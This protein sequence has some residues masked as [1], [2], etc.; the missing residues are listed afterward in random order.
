[1]K[2]CVGF[3]FLYLS[4]SVSN[5]PISKGEY[6]N[7]IRTVLALFFLFWYIAQPFSLM[8]TMLL[9][10]DVNMSPVQTGF[11]LNTVPIALFL[12]NYSSWAKYYI[13]LFIFYKYASTGL[14]LFTYQYV[15]MYL[16]T[17]IYNIYIHLEL[18]LF[19]IFSMYIQCTSGRIKAFVILC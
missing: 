8:M 9:N 13:P 3:I 19:T 7:V 2:A 12:L 14:A 15:S 17:S 6:V 11:K 18:L 5:K 4:I 1:M 16:Y 10:V